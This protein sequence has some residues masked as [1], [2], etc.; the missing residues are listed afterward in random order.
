MCSGLGL[1]GAGAYI[2][3][4]N[5]TRLRPEDLEVV[6][7]RGEVP[8]STRFCVIAA[9]TALD[10]LYL[11]TSSRRRDFIKAV[12]DATVLE[13][14]LK[15]KP[16]STL[17][18]CQRAQFV[19]F[20]STVVQAHRRQWADG[21][22]NPVGIF[23][24][25]QMTMAQNAVKDQVKGT[26]LQWRSSVVSS[27]SKY[28]SRLPEYVEPRSARKLASLLALHWW[29]SKYH[30]STEVRVFQVIFPLLAAWRYVMN[31]VNSCNFDRRTLRR[32]L[33][34]CRLNYVCYLTDS[35][36][37]GLQPMSWREL[38]RH[39]SGFAL[40]IMLQKRRWHDLLPNVL[41]QSAILNTVLRIYVPSYLSCRWL[42][43]VASVQNVEWLQSPRSPRTLL[44]HS[45]FSAPMKDPVASTA[46]LPI[47]RKS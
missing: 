39:I 28:C 47:R 31:R 44:D 22:S 8:L 30:D 36:V 3:T 17:D 12:N 4:T 29:A 41:R 26:W 25:Q 38:A 2:Q 34:F 16:S 27:G 24:E 35:I 19:A 37:P 7:H 14:S 15:A 13:D 20:L 43:N 32:V 1:L 18:E 9:R 46:S 5:L 10:S 33:H 42:L 6:R 21:R 11:W 40:Y 45:R 23:M